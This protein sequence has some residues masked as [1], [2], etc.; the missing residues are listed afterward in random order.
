MNS[1][2]S[3]LQ[4]PE[5]TLL[6]RCGVES[7]QP[8]V[9]TDIYREDTNIVVWQRN[10]SSELTQ[11][12]DQFLAAN[13]SFQSSMTLSPENA[14]VHIHDAL[15]NSPDTV[16]LS[17]N[18][19]ELVDMFCCLFELKH[20]G[21]RLT[22]LDRAMCPKFHV[23]RVPCRLVTTFLGSATQ[24]L[25]HHTVDRTKL[26]IGSNG[27]PDESSGL[28]QSVDDIRQL[29]AGDVA[30]LKGEMWEGNENAG[31]V[32]RSP[33]VLANERRLLLTLDFVN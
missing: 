10:L 28:I 2:N 29:K 11:T 32:H 21:L 22:V 1:L 23:D 26:G 16:E 7:D 12:V 19:A 17:E 13:P 15:G 4:E 30:L 18:I 3:T 5:H 31:L 24:W 27:L 9:L 14:V 8:D 20:A 25:P 33:A 6:Q